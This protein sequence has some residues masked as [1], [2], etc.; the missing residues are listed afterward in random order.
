[1]VCESCKHTVEDKSGYDDRNYHDAVIPN[2]K[3]PKCK[4]SRNDLGIKGKQTATR[5]ADN[6]II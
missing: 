6:E 3:C 5:Y 4:K 1:M 2:M